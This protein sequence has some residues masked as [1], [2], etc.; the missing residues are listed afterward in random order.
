MKKNFIKQLT[1]ALILIFSLF[2]LSCKESK[3]KNLIEL[4][5]ENYCELLDNVIKNNKE[6]KLIPNDVCSYYYSKEIVYPK[7]GCSL[8]K[9]KVFTGAVKFNERE[10]TGVTSYYVTEDQTFSIM[11]KL[12]NNNR[13]ITCL[14]NGKYY[15]GEMNI[16]E[17]LINVSSCDDVAEETK[18]DFGFPSFFFDREK[19]ISM[20][21]NEEIIINIYTQSI[22][23]VRIY[24]TKYDHFYPPIGVSFACTTTY[25]IRF[26]ANYE[27]AKVVK[28]VSAHEGLE[29]A[30]LNEVSLLYWNGSKKL[31]D[32]TVNMLEYFKEENPDKSYGLS[33][34]NIP[35]L[36]YF[37]EPYADLDTFYW[38]EGLY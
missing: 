34:E 38:M 12:Y 18:I 26:T 29:G 7:R 5:V 35:D 36:K 3:D 13:K 17:E 22:H 30:T 23:E 4:Q 28:E 9:N 16:A 1:L 24:K 37:S 15:S 14:S 33:K 6:G 10:T 19:M 11:G 8:I 20:I 32:E 25:I 31:L 27:I 21:R 2:L